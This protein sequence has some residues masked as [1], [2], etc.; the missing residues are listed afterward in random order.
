MNE[1]IKEWIQYIICIVCL[2]GAM[3]M[4]FLAMYIDPQGQ[5]HDS[6]LW[7]IGQ[8]LVFVGSMFGIS[9]IHNVQ[10]KKI[11]AKIKDMM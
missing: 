3:T 7:I 11:D 6:I 5:I 4:S 1:N 9:S 8:V 10:T 2:L